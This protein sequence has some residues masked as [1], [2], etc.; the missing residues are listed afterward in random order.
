MTMRME[1]EI[2]ADGIVRVVDTTTIAEHGNPQPAAATAQADATVEAATSSDGE[3][4]KLDRNS[5]DFEARKAELKKLGYKW[6]RNNKAW[7]KPTEANGSQTSAPAAQADWY[8]DATEIRLERSARDFQSKKE[9]LK[10]AGFQWDPKEKVWRKPAAQ[11]D[12]AVEAASYSYGEAVKLDCNS[13]EFEASK[14]ELKELGYKWDPKKK[15]WYRPTIFKIL[16]V[17][18]ALMAAILFFVTLA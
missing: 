4:V 5:T 15:A 17:P 14:A 12:A 9:S 6:E 10:S 2:G 1:I 13:P 3:T 11:A 18:L 7:R 8:G 16:K